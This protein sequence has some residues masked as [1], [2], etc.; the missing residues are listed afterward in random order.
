MRIEGFVIHL[1]R[2]EQRRPQVEKLRQMLPMPVHVV[3]AVDGQKLTQAEIDAVYG[4]KLH[5]PHYPFDLRAGEVGCFLSHR[6]AWREIVRRNLDAGLIVEDDVEVDAGLL[7][8]I[9]DLYAGTFEP[10]DY[11]RFPQ[12]LNEK[13]EAVASAGGITILEPVV[14]GLGM[15]LQLVG[16][17]AAAALLAETERFDR[18]VDT[19]IQLR[20]NGL[21]LLSSRPACVC[22]ISARIGGSVIQKKGKGFAEIISREVRRAIYRAK[23]RLTVRSGASG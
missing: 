16:R 5:R 13:G 10:S 18:P 1:A 11:L 2:A 15:V 22:E 9:L 4:R 19:T 20:R 7:Q 17:D 23:M 6:N 14:P 12:K 8:R 3:D 21:R